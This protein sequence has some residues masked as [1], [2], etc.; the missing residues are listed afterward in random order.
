[1][2]GILD[3]TIATARERIAYAPRPQSFKGLRIG[4]I[5]NSKKNSEAVLRA[6]A[7]KLE[8]VHG[9]TLAVLVHK[10][11]R[12]PLKDAQVAELQGRADFAIAGVG[13]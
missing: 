11:Q 13:D 8:V 10:P 9:M 12:A 2:L 3:P 7:Q 5:E 1:M 6:L 4:L